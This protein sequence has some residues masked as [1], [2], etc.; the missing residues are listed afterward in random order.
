MSENN[1]P[2]VSEEEIA[3]FRRRLFEAA[4][5][6]NPRAEPWRGYETLRSGAL[7]PTCLLTDAREKGTRFHLGQPLHDERKSLLA[8]LCERR[9]ALLAEQPPTTIVEASTSRPS[10]RFVVY[11]PDETLSDGAA[12]G[13]SDG[14]FDSDNEP[15]W[16]TWVWYEHGSARPSDGLR[17]ALWRP[18]VARVVGSGEWLEGRYFNADFAVAWVPR[19]VEERVA[20]GLW[21]NP[22]GCIDWLTNLDTPL[23][24]ALRVAGLLRPL[25]S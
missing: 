23:T 15:A 24:R 22:E 17:S 14:Y 5:W 21:A 10:G 18:V 3:L 11:W 19:A 13:S 12:D 6:C 9:A 1:G 8:S 16:D 2:S 25:P 20:H 7:Q 4:A